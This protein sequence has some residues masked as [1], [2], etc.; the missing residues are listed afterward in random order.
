MVVKPKHV[1]S[2]VSAVSISV[3]AYYWKR[4]TR[5]VFHK[6]I[7][8]HIFIQLSNV[9]VSE[10]CGNIL[11]LQLGTDKYATDEMSSYK[12]FKT[13]KKKNKTEKALLPG[14]CQWE[15][16]LPLPPDSSPAALPSRP[17]PVRKA[18]HHWCAF[19]MGSHILGYVRTCGHLLSS[20]DNFRNCSS[21]LHDPEGD[22]GTSDDWSP[23]SLE[24]YRQ[25]PQ[26]WYQ[27]SSWCDVKSIAILLF[28]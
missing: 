28:M 12:H 7:L 19:S 6:H 2:E 15:S 14:D 4:V 5:I 16:H 8:V 10:N 20:K 13:R 9:F 3:W 18:E 1:G 24:C 22:G 25:V 23:E 27:G 26:S 11:T 21:A 17:S